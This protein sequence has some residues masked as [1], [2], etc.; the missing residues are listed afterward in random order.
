MLGG[1]ASAIFAYGAALTYGATGSTN[2]TVIANVLSTT[3]LVKSGILLAG[4]GLLAVG[5]AF[6]NS[7]TKVIAYEQDPRARMELAN[8]VKINGVSKQV[9]IEGRCDPS[10]LLKLPAER[11]LMI[12]DCEGFEEQLL[13]SD[14]ISHLKNWDFIIETHDGYHPEISE[15]LPNDS[16]QPI[17]CNGSKPF[18]I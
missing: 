4:V 18:M 6:K 5:F 13:G 2:L 12:V 7:N 3:Y 11:G 1:F 15:R 14:A 16:G 9:A 17:G 10:T 8:L